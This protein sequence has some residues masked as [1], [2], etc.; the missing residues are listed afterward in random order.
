MKLSEL[1]PDAYRA[2]ETEVKKT[3][4]PALTLVDV[5]QAAAAFMYRQFKESIVLVRLYATLTH[6]RLPEGD[7]RF[8]QTVPKFS[9]VAPLIRDDTLVFSLMGSAGEEPA[10]NDR[11]NS[12]GH[13]GIPLV[14]QDFVDALPMVSRT[15]KELGVPMSGFM[16]VQSGVETMTFG[17]LGGMF[18]VED[19]SSTKDEKGRLIIPAQDFV[20]R[21]QVKTVFGTVGRYIS[22][23]IYVV[24]I[25]F[26]REHVT[27]FVASECMSLANAITASTVGVV[28]AGRLFG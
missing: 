4:S 2:F 19:A 10:W 7:R 28:Q 14:S 20:G 12:K 26:A 16:T 5:G 8:L 6:D 21:Y 22:G 23:G 17:R 11:R 27:K 13:L 24:L 18:Y 15:F 25:V 3:I 9:R 1:N